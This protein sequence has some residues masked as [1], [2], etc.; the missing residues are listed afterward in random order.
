MLVFDINIMLNSVNK[1]D[2]YSNSV[3]FSLLQCFTLYF[4]KCFNSYIYDNKVPEPK[5]IT[6]THI[7]CLLSCQNLQFNEL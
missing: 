7:P 5:H 2:L 4:Y 3:Y 1:I 6:V